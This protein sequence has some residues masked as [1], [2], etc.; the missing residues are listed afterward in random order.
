MIVISLCYN[1]TGTS[2]VGAISKA[3]IK[4]KGEPFADKTIQEKVA[5]C[6]KNRKGGPFT[7]IRFCRLRLK[8]KKPKGDPL[9]TKKIEKKSHSA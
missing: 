9:E 4:S 3:Q 6:R 7:L 8:S 2:Q 1:N 5:Q